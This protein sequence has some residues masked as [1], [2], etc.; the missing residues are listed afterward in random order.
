LAT[1][2]NRPIHTKWVTKGIRDMADAPRRELS[3]VAPVEEVDLELLRAAC[4]G[5]HIAGS[6]GNWHAFRG[7]IFMLDGPWSLWRHLH[8]DTLV[9]LAEQLGLQEYL[10]GLSEPELA[11]IWRRARL[12]KRSGQ[13]AS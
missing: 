13:A 3:E 4:P 7:G 12:P 11:G 2:N 8:A 9:A 10:D 5:W 1:R 6:P